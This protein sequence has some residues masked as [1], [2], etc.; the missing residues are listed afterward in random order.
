MQA[1]W[2]AVPLL[3]STALLAQT[4]GLSDQGDER[5]A[6]LCEEFIHETLALSPSAA[7]QAGYHRHV[8]SKTGKTIELDALLDDVSPGGMTEQRRVYS[9]WRNRFHAEAPISSLEA[10]DAA[11]WRLIDDQ[12]ALNLLDRPH[13]ELQA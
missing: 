7:S 10:E 3:I 1:F 9:Q 5:F 6:Q 11:D 4:S 13:P 8:D 12:I 2:V